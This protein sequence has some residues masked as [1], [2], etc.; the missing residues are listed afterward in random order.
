MTTPD[1][2]LIRPSQTL[3]TFERSAP[4]SVVR[5]THHS[6]EPEEDAERQRRRARDVAGRDPEAREQRRERQDRHRVGERQAE[7]REVGAGQAP[8]PLGRRGRL[9]R[10]G[11]RRLP[12]EPQ[13]ER[14]AH[15]ARGSAGRRRAGP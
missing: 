13:Q 8:A 10:F 2:T 14:A 7:R 9:G 1:T 6:A 12:G 5:T 15:E 3:V 4:T 11:A